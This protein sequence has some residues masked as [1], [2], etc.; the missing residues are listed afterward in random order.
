VRR[1]AEAG[2]NDAENISGDLAA[3]TLRSVDADALRS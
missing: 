1:A 2:G 3:L